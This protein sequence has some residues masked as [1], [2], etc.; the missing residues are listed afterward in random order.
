MPTKRTTGDG[1]PYSDAEEAAVCDAIEAAMGDEYDDDGYP[2]SGSTPTSVEI[3]AEIEWAGTTDHLRDGVRT[4]RLD[5]L[6]LHATLQAVQRLRQAEGR[7]RGALRSYKAKGWQAQL[8]QLGRVKRGPAAMA[9]AALMPSRETMR[10]WANGQQKPSR[11]NREKISR[12]YDE[13][14]NPARGKV[15]QARHDVAEKFTQALR[16]RYGVNVRL[17]NIRNL[18]F[19]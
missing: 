9:A 2:A 7:D 8:R 6:D 14:R 11:A 18:T 3:T 5:G 17:R 1:D 16:S 15:T 19:L 12:A 13:L 4:T 10:R